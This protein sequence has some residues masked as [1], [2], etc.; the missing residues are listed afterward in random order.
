VSTAAALSTDIV[1]RD[2]AAGYERTRPE[3]SF[4]RGQHEI[5]YQVTG[6]TFLVDRRQWLLAAHKRLSQLGLLPADWDNYGAEAPSRE[7]IDAARGILRHLADVQ[8][9]PT[10][11]DPSAEGGV[12]LCFQRGDRYADIECFNSGE[13]LAVTSTGGDDTNVWQI[14]EPGTPLRRALDRIRSFVGR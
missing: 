4:W 11:V 12:C 14:E 13:I 8:L 10:S 9:E 2:F 3:R 5:S 7:S 6:V 1:E